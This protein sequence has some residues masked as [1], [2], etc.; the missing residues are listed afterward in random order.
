MPS[1][2]SCIR[3]QNARITEKTDEYDKIFLAFY[4]ISEKNR[5][6]NNDKS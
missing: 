5:N 6:H 4:A 2:I 3:D 1:G